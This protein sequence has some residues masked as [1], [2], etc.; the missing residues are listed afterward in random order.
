MTPTRCIEMTPMLLNRIER[1]FALPFVS[2]AQ[3][4]D[5]RDWC[6]TN[7]TDLLDDLP[8]GPDAWRATTSDYWSRYIDSRMSEEDNA[9]VC[10]IIDKLEDSPTPEQE[11]AL[12][13]RWAE[14]DEAYEPRPSERP[15]VWLPRHSC[16]FFLRTQGALAL[17]LFPERQWFGVANDMHTFVV[18]ADGEVFDLLLH[19]SFDPKYH[20]TDQGAE[21]LPMSR[22]S[23]AA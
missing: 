11:D 23:Q 22:Q 6:T 4:L 13:K 2:E 20:R 3:E 14:L 16:H 18:D 5:M 7:R 1:A 12:H 17:T 8:L 15:D 21:V 9:V 10:E 19:D